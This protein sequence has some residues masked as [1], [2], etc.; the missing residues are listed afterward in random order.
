MNPRVISEI[1]HAREH[2][3]RSLQGIG[4]NE[5]PSRKLPRLVS[6]GRAMRPDRVVSTVSQS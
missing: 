4:S 5:G 1:F 3:E 2:F 6:C